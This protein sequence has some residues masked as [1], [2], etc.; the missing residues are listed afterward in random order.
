MECTFDTHPFYNNSSNGR[1]KQKKKTRESKN[2][3]DEKSFIKWLVFN[4]NGFD[5]V[6]EEFVGSLPLST[7]Q[8]ASF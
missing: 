5:A 6:A 2:Q 4:C 8:K 1:T 3:K 7:S